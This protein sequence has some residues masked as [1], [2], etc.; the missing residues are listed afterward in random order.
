MLSASFMSL[1]DLGCECV[2]ASI[3]FA[4]AHLRCS[5][6]C[7]KAFGGVVLRS[8]CFWV[9][10]SLPRSHVWH[11][12]FPAYVVF[13]IGFCLL[14]CWFRHLIRSSLLCVCTY[15]HGYSCTYYLDP[16]AACDKE[17]KLYS[18]V[19]LIEKK[20]KKKKK[21]QNWMIW[22]AIHWDAFCFNILCWNQMHHDLIL[23]LSL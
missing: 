6:V 7:I 9:R 15:L 2:Y 18:C 19:R 22:Y 3:V 12:T 11:L 1:P 13:W 21:K 20:K 8:S 23:P 14:P 17:M 5:D 4:S 10:M 16:P